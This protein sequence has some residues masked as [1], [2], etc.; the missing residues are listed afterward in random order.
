MGRSGSAPAAG[1]ESPAR[2]GRARASLAG[3]PGGGD[4]LR[5]HPFSRKRSERG[6][7]AERH[8]GSRPV[9]GR[10]PEA[11][12]SEG[13]VWVEPV[14]AAVLS[15]RPGRAR[16][17]R[18]GLRSAGRRSS[19]RAALSRFP[20]HGEKG[21]HCLPA[22]PRRA[23]AFPLGGPDFF[24]PARPDP[25]AR[26][27]VGDPHRRRVRLRAGGPGFAV[28]PSGNPPP[29]RQGLCPFGRPG[30]PSR[31][32]G[33]SVPRSAGVPISA[34]EGDGEMDF[35]SFGKRKGFTK[36]RELAFLI[37]FPPIQPIQIYIQLWETYAR[38][39]AS[40]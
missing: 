15:S 21:V 40:K 20:P 33:D 32:A 22:A 30:R 27:R 24:S 17:E 11:F 5:M 36:P 2:L 1:G 38:S 19:L 10:P 35:R 3:A 23:G 4:P 39:A 25:P 18:V 13:G 12:Q 8:G 16:P 14:D 37:V 9:R 7:S 34:S 26:R 29:R 28:G 6:F 31:R